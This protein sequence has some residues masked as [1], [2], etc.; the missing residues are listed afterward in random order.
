MDE[1][2]LFERM[3]DRV[4]EMFANT[5][6]FARY[7]L[8]TEKGLEDKIEGFKTLDPDEER[9]DLVG[10][11]VFPF[12]VRSRPPKGVH[13]LWVRV[14]RSTNGVI[15][16]AESDRYGPASLKDGEVAFYNKIS[17]TLILLDENGKVSITAAT[18]QV[19]ELNG[20]S[21]S[22]PKTETLLAAIGGLSQAL[23]TVLGAATDAGIVAA[24]AA[25][26][27][28]PIQDPS[29][30]V[31]ASNSQAIAGLFAVLTPFKSTKAKNG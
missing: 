1:R 20:N 27:L 3:M 25:P 2:R 21:F 13:A 14:G 5:I 26:P 4:R 10:R 23:A 9:Y 16:G 17:G 11:R 28:P 31:F 18:G 12:G 29:G 15:V 8:S 7:T 19:L 24:M 22:L 30:G 6:Q